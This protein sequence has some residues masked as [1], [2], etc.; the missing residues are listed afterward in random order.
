MAGQVGSSS[1]MVSTR[2]RWARCTHAPSC[3]AARARRAQRTLRVEISS[4]ELGTCSAA[5]ARQHAPSALL[6]RCAAVELAE[7]E[8]V[9]AQPRFCM[10][11]R[12]QERKRKRAKGSGRR[13]EGVVHAAPVGQPSGRQQGLQWGAPRCSPPR[14]VRCAAPAQPGPGCLDEQLSSLMHCSC[15]HGWGG[16]S[17]I[18]GGRRGAT[19]RAHCAQAMMVLVCGHV[20]LSSPPRWTPVVFSSSPDTGSTWSTL[21]ARSAQRSEATA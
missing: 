1:A 10:A 21:S 2:A 9:L 20:L 14:Q 15:S 12:A 6:R 5:A 13:L 17:Q 18:L 16:P 11:L 7:H 3:G 8:V 4:D 19:H